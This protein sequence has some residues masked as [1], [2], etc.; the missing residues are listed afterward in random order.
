M[1]KRK[2]TTPARARKARGRKA[3]PRRRFLPIL[4]GLLVWCMLGVAA[5]CEWIDYRVR[6]DFSALTWALPGRIYARP[7][8]LYNGAHVD[9]AGMSDTLQRLGYRETSEVDGPGEF[10][11]AGGGIQMYTRGF[12]FWD[13][14]EP[15]RYVEVGFSG[16]RI[17]SLRD[18]GGS[19]P[20]MRLEPIEIAQINPETGEDRL[21][22]ALEDV[23]PALVRAVIAV[24][25]QRF[26]GHFCID[27]I[28]IARALVANIRAGGVV[29]GGSTL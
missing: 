19:V 14:N 24:E 27:P 20:L 8:E 9:R 29:Q 16:G 1:V 23:P 18:R 2:R 13:G 6:T 28:G 25:D 15:G 11:V 21:P 5:W 12:D 22:V 7:V 17:A 26:Y 4:G 3:P 10:R